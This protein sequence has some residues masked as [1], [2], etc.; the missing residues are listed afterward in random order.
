MYLVIEDGVVVE[1]GNK[2]DVDGLVKR[3]EEVELGEE[4]K[5][6]PREFVMDEDF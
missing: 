3:M 5:E 6:E 1:K 4:K 2:V